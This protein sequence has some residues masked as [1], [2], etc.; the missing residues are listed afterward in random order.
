MPC[1]EG[2]AFRE[3]ERLIA[4]ATNLVLVQVHLGTEWQPVT[5]AN[6]MANIS[7]LRDMIKYKGSLQTYEKYGTAT[8]GNFWGYIETNQFEN[9]RFIQVMYFFI[10]RV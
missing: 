2:E 7:A 9:L 1:Q 5:K 6:I 10:R 4:V 8:R 3:V